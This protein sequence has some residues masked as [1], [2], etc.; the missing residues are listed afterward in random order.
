MNEHYLSVR[1]FVKNP[2]NESDFTI[3]VNFHMSFF[4][5]IFTASSYMCLYES[6]F[7]KRQHHT[8]YIVL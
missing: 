2:I 6:M 4:L 5:N 7:K 3:I 1:K 8:D